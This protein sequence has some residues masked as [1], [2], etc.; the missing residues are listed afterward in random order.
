MMGLPFELVPKVIVI[1]ASNASIK[2]IR[3]ID[4]PY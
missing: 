1:I 3:F 4:F 2:K